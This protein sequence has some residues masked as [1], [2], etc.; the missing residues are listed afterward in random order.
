MYNMGGFAVDNTKTFSL[1]VQT[2]VIALLIGAIV[3]FFLYKII[4]YPI[5]HLNSQVSRS[6]R[7]GHSDLAMDY[8]FPELQELIQNL[9][10]ALARSSGGNSFSEQGQYEHERG[11]EAS[12]VLQLIGFPA[13]A[14]NAQSMQ[15]TA[16]NDH[17]QGQI[18]K[19]TN[20]QDIHLNDVLDQALRLNI[21]D[22]VERCK[23]QP[24]QLAQDD[25]EIDGVTYEINGQAVFGSSDVNY[26]V[27]TFTPSEGIG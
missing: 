10:S 17:F 15:V 18:G 11:A 6:L 14:V 24:N 5:T 2:L 12:G 13:I 7:D 19:T 26:I 1:F 9:Q 8:D 4:L 20:W 27:V 22:I 25:L 16:V 21:S 23:A 3:F